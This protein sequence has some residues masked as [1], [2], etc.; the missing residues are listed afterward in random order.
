MWF[1]WRRTLAAVMRM[2]LLATW[3][4]GTCTVVVAIAAYADWAAVGSEAME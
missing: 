4:P 3:E 2:A 1:L